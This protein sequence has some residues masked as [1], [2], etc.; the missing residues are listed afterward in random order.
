MTSRESYTQ[1]G[2]KGFEAA[3]EQRSAAR[4]AAFFLPDIR[5][6]MRLLDLGCGPGTITLGLGTHVAPGEVIGV[7]FQP[8]VIE[9]ARTLAAQ[10]GIPNAGFEV[11]D[12]YHLP[13]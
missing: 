11:G 9:R 3:L 6:G 7:D 2:N 5:P 4:E 10:R 13:F 8:S 12:I 1:Q